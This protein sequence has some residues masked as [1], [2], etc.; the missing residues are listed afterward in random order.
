MNLTR[1]QLPALTIAVVAAAS[2]PLLIAGVP[3]P[4]QAV[5]ALTLLAFLPGFALLRLS[6]GREPIQTAALSIALSLALATVLATSLLY[7]GMWSWQACVA[8]L[9]GIAL[10]ASS[11]RVRKVVA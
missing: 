2:P 11:L 7:V 1:A 8:I 4:A 6:P 9:G 3:Q 5:L 10:V